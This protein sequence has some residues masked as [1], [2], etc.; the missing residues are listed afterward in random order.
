ML[1]YCGILGKVVL[2][3]FSM[4]VIEN[5]ESDFSNEPSVAARNCIVKSDITSCSVV[6]AVAAA[7]FLCVNFVYGART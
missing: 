2:N 1:L 3:F 5:W 4:R 7:A 6:E